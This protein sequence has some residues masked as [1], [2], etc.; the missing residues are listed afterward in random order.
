M[1]IEIIYIFVRIQPQLMDLNMVILVCGIG[2][3][4][5]NME[6]KQKIGLNV[7]MFLKRYHMKQFFLEIN[8][9]LKMKLKL[10]YF[11]G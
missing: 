8:I 7:S 6:T 1:K 4:L 10:F 5:L 11:K 2:L 9:N 3:L